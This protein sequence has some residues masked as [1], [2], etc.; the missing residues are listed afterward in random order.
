M[1]YIILGLLVLGIAF[2]IYAIVTAGDVHYYIRYKVEEE[3]EIPPDSK[4]KRGRGR[5]RKNKYE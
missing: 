1:D 5:P 4:P 2:N 3:S